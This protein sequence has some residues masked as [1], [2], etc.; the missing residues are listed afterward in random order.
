MFLSNER[1]RKKVPEE[2]N[3]LKGRLE[4]DSPST[5]S[6]GALCNM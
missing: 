6:G 1:L 2:N 5:A 4:E 3:F